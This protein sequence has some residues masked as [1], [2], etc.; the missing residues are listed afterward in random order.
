MKKPVLIGV[1]FVLIVLGVIVYTSFNL[2]SHTVEVCMGFGGQTACRTASGSSKDFAL[3]TAINNACSQIS[4]G[5]T[6]SGICE[7]SEPLKET[8]IK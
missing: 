2:A 8:W 5:V 3:R 6:D 1:V 7:R 4:S